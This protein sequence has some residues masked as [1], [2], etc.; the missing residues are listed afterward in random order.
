MQTGNFHVYVYVH[1]CV[2]DYANV[3]VRVF[4][5]VCVCKNNKV[6]SAREVMLLVALVSLFLVG[7][8]NSFF[9]LFF[10]HIQCYY[11]YCCHHH[12]S[13]HYHYHHHCHQYCYYLR[14][15]AYVF[16]RVGWLLTLFVMNRFFSKMF[17]RRVPQP[18][19]DAIISGYYLLV[20][21]PTQKSYERILGGFC[22]RVVPQPNIDSIKFCIRFV[23]LIQ[24]SI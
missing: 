16:G 2:F 5:Y 1:V 12:S 21:S 8:Q 14:Q 22:T 13:S 24:K 19:L 7:Q 18:N 10:Y 6:T 3:Y 17:T 15:G 20:S 23:I 9:F 11:Y 4:V